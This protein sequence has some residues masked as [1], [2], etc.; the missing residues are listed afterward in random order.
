MQIVDSL[1]DSQS[2]FCLGHYMRL[3]RIKRADI[4]DIIKSNCEIW[5]KGIGE[6]DK[7]NSEFT[8]IYSAYYAQSKSVTPIKDCLEQ[9][10]AMKCYEKS[11]SYMVKIYTNHSTAIPATELN[12]FVCFFQDIKYGYLY[13]PM[14]I[15]TIGYDESLEDG[16]VKMF[17]ILYFTD[18]WPNSLD[19]IEDD[20]LSG[21]IEN[22]RVKKQL[23]LD[24]LNKEKLEN[25]WTESVYQSFYNDFFKDNC[26]NASIWR[27]NFSDKE[28]L[29]NYLVEKENYSVKNTA[30]GLSEMMFLFHINGIE[31]NVT[32][33]QFACRKIC[34]AVRHGS[35]LLLVSQGNSCLDYIIKCIM[36]LEKSCNKRQKTKIALLR[37]TEKFL[38]ENK[39]MTATEIR[40]VNV[41]PLLS[42]VHAG[43]YDL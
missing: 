24:T 7:F 34:W 5:D 11:W 22:Y 38:L 19:D 28:T 29:Y 15:V 17:Q 41:N 8:Y 6:L 23:L 30:L 21:S 42:G 3:D 25:E 43:R 9:F 40:S 10:K 26:I 13:D 18:R 31:T 4:P 16:M 36:A 1:V 37:K 35:S 2:C 12:K 32:E 14:E 39:A 27:K 20:A 33:I